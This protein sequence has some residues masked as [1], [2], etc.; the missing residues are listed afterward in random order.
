MLPFSNSGYIGEH[1]LLFAKEDDA[2]QE[3]EELATIA[4]SLEAPKKASSPEVTKHIEGITG[5]TVRE[6]QGVLQKE[7]KRWM[8]KP[9][10][11]EL[12][13]KLETAISREVSKQ[14]QRVRDEVAGTTN[15][16]LDQIEK[17]S[18]ITKDPLF[19]LDQRGRALDTLDTG[20]RSKLET[21]TKTNKRFQ[22]VR[23][24]VQNPVT[25]ADLTTLT[26]LATHL[27]GKKEASA[28]VRGKSPELTEVNAVLSAEKELRADLMALNLPYF[29][30]QPIT[31]HIF[32]AALGN[33][34]ALKNAIQNGIADDKEQKR[35]LILAEKLTLQSRSWLKPWTWKKCKQQNRVLSYAMA[36][37]ILEN[38]RKLLAP[39]IQDRL[40]GLQELPLGTEVRIDMGGEEDM[41]FI[42]FNQDEKGVVFL[43][44]RD[45]NGLYVRVNSK[46]KTAD[47]IRGNT[48]TDTVT[49]IIPEGKPEVTDSILDLSTTRAVKVA[50]E[51]DAEAKRRKDEEEAKARE[52]EEEQEE[53][54]STET[55]ERIAVFA[56]FDAA[57]EE[58]SGTKGKEATLEENGDLPEMPEKNL[59]E[60][61]PVD[62]VKAMGEAGG[63]SFPDTGEVKLEKEKVM[64][65]DLLGVYSIPLQKDTAEKPK[66][67]SKKIYMDM[68]KLSQP[69]QSVEPSTQTQQQPAKQP[70]GGRKNKRRG[71]R[72]RG[73][74][75]R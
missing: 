36:T 22:A 30:T 16:Y 21:D 2:E 9:K 68:S 28:A 61:T 4:A 44:C 47:F 53:K 75:R 60:I 5:E 7:K 55:K 49:L 62:G 27:E 19:S 64:D 15:F 58:A 67:E 20:G 31:Q 13:K 12:P 24:K 26:E 43:H 29:S 65:M 73:G 40:K 42:K 23:G 18:R 11:G 25:E 3:V 69:K 74:K 50:R 6:L 46:K 41:R 33:P 35:L 70:A 34:L 45:E 56:A 37:E 52:N 48:V 32:N 10:P 54:E 8:F 72:R 57:E 38:E 71:N 17:S 63:V 51:R 1:R 59:Y 39:K 66:E 14:V